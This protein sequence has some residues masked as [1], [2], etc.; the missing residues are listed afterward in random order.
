ML[1]EKDIE[2]LVS[3]LHRER[4]IYAA[5]CDLARRQGE[6]ISAGDCVEAL[7]K[8]LGRKQVLIN[9]V[10]MMEWTLAPL[11]RAWEET[12]EDHDWELRARIEEGVGDLREVLAELVELEDR[13]GAKLQREQQVMLDVMK[14]GRSREA[15]RAYGKAARTASV[16]DNTG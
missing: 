10:E 9:E 3:G 7:L 8:L 4:E 14:F 1:A 16:L 5:L 2:R 6:I 11:K 12:R 15:H 13:T